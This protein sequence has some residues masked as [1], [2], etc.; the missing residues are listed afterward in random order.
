MRSR[1]LAV[2]ATSLCAAFMLPVSSHALSYDA[3][4]VF[5]DSLSDRGNLA[6]TGILQTEA[7]L[8]ITNF[9]NPPS[10]HDS[11]GNG[12]PA[13]Q[14]LAN[15]LGLNANPS[16]WVT[17]FK[18]VNNL[19]GGSSYTPGTNYAVAGAIAAPSLPTG[20]VPGANLPQQAAAYLAATGGKA[21]PNAL[22]TV[23]I[24]GNDVRNAALYGN[25][26]TGPAGIATG[27]MT[28]VGV[29]EALSAAGARNFL[30]PNVPNVGII[31]EF[32]Q[33]NPTLAAA[34]SNYSVSYD[35][36][37]ATD[38]A[39]LTLPQGTDLTQFNLYA[40][41]QEIAANAAALG[42]TNTTDRCFTNTP[43]SAA[44][45]PQ[46][47][48]DG[49]NVDSF[50]YWDSIHPTAPVQALWAEGML[51]ALEGNP[52]PSPISSPVPEPASLA[53]LGAGLLGVAGLRRRRA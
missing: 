53:L 17:G 12:P 20:G 26:T 50:I 4:Y 27:V 35:S 8:P 38:L 2:A 48:P 7:G 46:C 22:Y 39:A 31:P 34:A 33:D 45:T 3:E 5:G 43:L 37:L 10:N 24:G 19:F 23:F 52:N 25:S 11:F 32:A 44:A 30:V 14:L 41:N 1:T 42:F 49:Q 21:D 36:Q 16:V 40:Y 13:V 6:E 18:D 47:G 29:I 15:D 28:E 9:P 51:D